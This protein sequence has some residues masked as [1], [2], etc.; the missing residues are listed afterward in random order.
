VHD[1]SVVEAVRDAVQARKAEYGIDKEKMDQGLERRSIPVQEC[2]LQIAEDNAIEGEKV[3]W[4]SP[5]DFGDYLVFVDESGDHGLARVDPGY[6]IFVLAFCLLAKHDYVE[7]IGPAL[8]QL[9][10]R[11]WGH[12]EQVLHEHEIRKPDKNYGFLFDPARRT[13]FIEALNILVDKG[14]FQLVAVV[15]RKMEFA[16]QYALPANPYDLALQLGLE[17]VYLELNS[18]GQAARTT[19]IIVEKR[20]EKEDN[21]LELA[22]R[23]ICAGANGLNRRF[24]FEL[25][26]IS[27]A[28]NSTG[29]Q[30]ADLVARPIGIK[31]LRPS[32]PNRAYDIVGK[33]LCRSPVGET[34]D[35]GLIVVP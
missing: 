14:T 16:K 2:G 21:Q 8:Q 25:V 11:F 4:P 28:S 15:I 13:E 35:W 1:V 20:G 18:R 27:K 6:P 22:F 23:R 30:M 33:K 17:R 5:D 9:K 10:F 24:A 26:M 3:S 7:Q 29:L 32:Q 19:H 31:V 12:D 34:K